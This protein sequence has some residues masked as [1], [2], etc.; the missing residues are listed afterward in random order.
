MGP[1]VTTKSDIGPIWAAATLV[2]YM[3]MS[4]CDQEGVYRYVTNDYGPPISNGPS[5]DQF[6]PRPSRIQANLAGHFG[7]GKSN[8]VNTGRRKRRTDGER[9]MK[10]HYSLLIG[11]CAAISSAYAANPDLQTAAS[12]GILASTGVTNADSQTTINGSVG[13]AP[14]TPAVTGITAAMVTGGTLYTTANAVTGQAQTDATN[15]F[16]TAAGAPCP[17]AHDFTGQDLGGKALAAGASNVYCFSSSAGLTGVLTLTGGPSDVF[18]FQIPTTLITGT[19]SSVMLSGGLSACNIFW[20]V[21][22]S[23]TIASNNNFVGTI[24]AHTSITLNGGSL[25]GRAL[26][27]TGAV[28]I[29]GKE[30]LVSGCSVSSPIILLAPASSANVCGSGVSTLE[31][32]TVISNG[33]PLAG[34]SVTFSIVSGPGLGTFG[35]VVTGGLGTASF[36]VPP[37]ALGS[38][39]DSIVA[40]FTDA[41]SQTWTSN[42]V[43]VSCVAPSNPDVTAP[44]LGIVAMIAGPPKQVVFSAQDTGSG[45]ASVVVNT[46][47]NATVF[48]PPIANGTI[49]LVGITATKIDQSQSAVI[50]LTATDVAGNVTVFDPVFATLIIPAAGSQDGDLTFDHQ[51]ASHLRG[52]APV[53]GTIRIQNGAPGVAQLVFKVNGQVF[54]ALLTDGQFQTVDISAALHPGNNNVNVTAFG[55]PNSSVDVVISDGK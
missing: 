2:D 1:F 23:A 55:N 42:T 3:V 13:S 14:A 35:P 33:L 36:S 53:E 9:S 40:R 22:S 49:D 29:T 26:A 16:N 19:N 30:T 31:T 34:V 8:I 54:E 25:L 39:P 15:A 28:T 12:F 18:I 44:F 37:L 5:L 10:R 48:I 7:S 20:E 50:K 6:A 11:V 43:A 21:G 38:A 52:I 24:L 17:A 51:K 32:A 4:N 47:T 41:S 46:S 27:N 45:L